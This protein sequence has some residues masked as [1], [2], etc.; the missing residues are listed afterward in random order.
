M[1]H[2]S[3]LLLVFV[4]TSSGVFADTLDQDP[5][6]AFAEGVRM[7]EAKEYAGAAAALDVAI[8]I[9]PTNDD[10][11]H[12]RGRAYGRLAEQASWFSAVKFAK[13]TR[14]SFERAVQINPNNSGALADL[15]QYYAEAPGFLGGDEAKAEVLRAR[16]K[17]L[18]S[19][20]SSEAAV[21]P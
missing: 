8:A 16:L 2:K 6:L 19:L 15:A 17:S 12:W 11:F 7:F 3:L 10:Y 9:A 4:L 1:L 5:A 13:L 20:G 14:D 18:P 21:T